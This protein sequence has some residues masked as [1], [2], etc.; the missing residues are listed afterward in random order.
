MSVRLRSNKRIRIWRQK[1]HYKQ[2]IKYLEGEERKEEQTVMR[3]K[4]KGKWK[5]NIFT[6]GKEGNSYGKGRQKEYALIKIRNK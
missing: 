3:K 2:Y 6:R 5:I 4:K 1:E